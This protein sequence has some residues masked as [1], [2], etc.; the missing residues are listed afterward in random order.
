MDS[1]VQTPTLKRYRKAVA[2][3]V[4]YAAAN[5]EDFG[6]MDDLLFDQM[7]VDYLQQLYN[8]GCSQSEAKDTYSGVVHFLPHLRKQLPWTL[9][10][11]KGWGTLEPSQSWP[12][13]T[14]GLVLTVA[15]ALWERKDYAHATALLLSFECYLRSG[16]VCAL[17]VKDVALPGDVRLGTMSTLSTLGVM[18]AKTGRYQHV[19]VRDPLVIHLL[20]LFTVGAAPDAPLLPGVSQ[21]SLR[22]ALRHGLR[23]VG[24]PDA[25]YVPHSCRHGGATHDYLLG[26]LSLESVLE[27]GRWASSKSARTYLQSARVLL[28]LQQIP[29]ETAGLIRLREGDRGA[30]FGLPGHFAPR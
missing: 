17:Q 14:Y 1:A 19:T 6:A 25:P 11:L 7:L 29:P 21:P 27:R 8:N 5:E 13:I 16:E 15:V 30:S 18:K 10:A 2:G 23:L 22:K 4:A 12:P 20:S 26:G 24:M 3:F 9:R 28:L